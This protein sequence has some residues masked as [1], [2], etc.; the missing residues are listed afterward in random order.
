MPVRAE[1]GVIGQRLE[2]PQLVQVAYPAFTDLA[3]DQFCQTR[4]GQHHPAPRR[5][6]VGL[7]A[8]LL[9]PQLGKVT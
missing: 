4:V 9:G 7:I 2:L 1:T 6:A 5:H 3:G 8:E